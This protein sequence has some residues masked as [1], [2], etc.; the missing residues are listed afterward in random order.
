MVAFISTMIA[1]MTWLVLGLAQ[2][3]PLI[4]I[5]GTLAVFV[6]IGATMLHYVLSCM[7]RHCAQLGHHHHDEHSHAANR[8]RPQL[9][10]SS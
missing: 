8:H 5:S 7:R 3:D 4:Q 2:R 10:A 1:F 9:N 6:A